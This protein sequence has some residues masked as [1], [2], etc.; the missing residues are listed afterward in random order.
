MYSL[1]KTTIQDI[2]TQ[3]GLLKLLTSSLG[4]SHKT[5]T[6]STLPGTLSGETVINNRYRYV[7]NTA[8]KSV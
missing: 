2:Q 1:Q 7:S 4:Q 6:A 3:N 5:A 8:R